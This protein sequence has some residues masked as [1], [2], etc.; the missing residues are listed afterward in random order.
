MLL[1]RKSE[2][3]YLQCCIPE[4]SLEEYQ[5]ELKSPLKFPATL[6]NQS[7]CR[8]NLF[9]DVGHFYGNEWLTPFC[10][11]KILKHFYEKITKRGVTL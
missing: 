4:L 2:P 6:R 8:K 10:H 7:G 3:H 9:H 5:E 11:L 1:L